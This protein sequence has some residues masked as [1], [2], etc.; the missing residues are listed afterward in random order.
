M[1]TE[2]KKPLKIDVISD[3]I[4]PFCFIGKRNLDKAISIS[5]EQNIPLS[6]D[7]EFHPFL[8]DPSQKPGDP[9]Q[10]KRQRYESKFGKERF[11]AMKQMMKERG[12]M[13]GIDF[14]YDGPVSQTTDSHR[15]LS[16]AYSRGGTPLQS[17]LIER[18]FSGYFE[19]NAD[20]GSP[21]FLATSAVEAGVFPTKEEAK[22]WVEGDELRNEVTKGVRRAQMMGVSGVPFF[23][24]DQ[25]YAISGAEDPELFVQVFD[26]IAK[27]E[28]VQ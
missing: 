17:A 8:L 28:L 6:F 27:G 20:V 5:A 19:H 14:S 7:V 2:T 23:L 21:E 3:S 25:K 1:A 13:V 12:K 4:C 22:E 15:L 16:Y 26:K 24:I 11:A 9:P 10:D 18:L